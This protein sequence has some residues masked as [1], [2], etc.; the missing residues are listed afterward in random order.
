MSIVRAP[1]STLEQ[2]YCVLL[3][4]GHWLSTEPPATS[5]TG[6]RF[7]RGH[8]SVEQF[9]GWLTKRRVV[10]LPVQA[11]AEDIVNCSFLTT[12]C[13]NIRTYSL[14]IRARLYLGYSP[15]A[16]DRRPDHWA[17]PPPTQHFLHNKHV[18]VEACISEGPVALDAVVLTYYV[19]VLDINKFQNQDIK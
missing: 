8:K 10:I 19:F 15:A 4:R 7:R 13:R 17:T 5:G 1:F 11:V 6:R 14:T 12:P 2:G 9:A 3:T 16:R 18:L